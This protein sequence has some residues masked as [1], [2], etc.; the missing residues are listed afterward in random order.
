MDKKTVIG[1]L[2][3]GKQDKRS[4]FS[5]LLMALNQAPVKNFALTAH[6]NRVGYSDKNLSSIEYDVKKAFSISAGELRTFAKTEAKPVEA[7]GTKSK[8]KGE[9][10]KD[11]EEQR[12]ESKEKGEE[13]EDSEKSEQLEIEKYNEQLKAI[14]TEKAD[15]QEMVS[16]AYDLAEQLNVELPNKKKSTVVAFLEEQKKSLANEA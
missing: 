6:Y 10:K 9:Q 5:M 11:S 16:L 8:E 14:D 7:K 2:K 1:I 4:K 13:K 15:Y 3:D 12:E